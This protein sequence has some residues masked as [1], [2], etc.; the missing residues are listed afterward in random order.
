MKRR[1]KQQTIFTLLVIAIAGAVGWYFFAQDPGGQSGQE[2]DS[3]NAHTSDGI[4]DGQGSALHTT[5]GVTGA[6]NPEG[7]TGPID[8]KQH[9]ELLKPDVRMAA[10]E[11]S[12][13]YNEALGAVNQDLTEEEVIKLR[14][15]L[16]RAYFSYQL[17]P[18]QQQRARQILT[19]L[20]GKT[21]YS[22]ISYDG[23]PYTSYYVIKPGDMLVKLDQKF[24]LRTPDELLLEVN[25]RLNPQTLRPGTRIK[26]MHGVYHAIVYKSEYVMDLYLKTWDKPLTFAGRVRV[27]LGKED[28]T[29]EG[30]FQVI[31]KGERIAWNPPPGSEFKK[32]IDWGEPNYPLGKDGLWVGLKGVQEANQHYTGY[33]LHGTNDPASVGRSESLGCIRMLDKDIQFAYNRLYYKWSTVHIRE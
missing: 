18:T 25:P 20:A 33:G 17:R 30:I 10:H 7:K 9:P 13:I 31:K 14:S 24:K 16:S 27:G 12:S 6:E 22:A 19:D 32:R 5:A 11:A 26:L 29:P 28:A 15:K 3:V 4:G 8:P 1:Q 23:D 2:S 21:L